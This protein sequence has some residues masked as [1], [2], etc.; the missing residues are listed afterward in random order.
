MK[1]KI[2]TLII[3]NVIVFSSIAIFGVILVLITGDEN[4]KCTF[5]N[6]L[7]LYCPG[8]GGTRAFFALLKFDIIASLRYNPLV[9][10]GGLTYLYY[11][12]RAIIAIKKND[13]EY[14]K[15]ERYFIIPIVIVICLIYYVVRDV[16]LFYGIDLI[17]D[18]IKG[19]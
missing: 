17:G 1:K 12:I 18:I 3:T 15:K 10:L 19:V 9:I 13:E 16:L 5:L 14:F 4:Y 11:N 6:A 8:C 7:H 2:K